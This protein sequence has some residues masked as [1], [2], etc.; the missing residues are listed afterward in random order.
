ME[1]GS[2]KFGQS[3]QHL[4]RV[5][6]QP[7]PEEVLLTVL[8]EV[9]AILNSKP[10]GYVSADIANIDPVAPN[11]SLMGRPDVLMLMA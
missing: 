2:G 11:S 9:E 10:L 7:V 6:S 3:S 4:T 5:G 1:Y 8:L